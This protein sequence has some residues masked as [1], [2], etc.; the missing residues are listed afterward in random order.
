MPNVFCCPSQCRRGSESTGLTNYVAV[1]GENTAWPGEVSISFADFTDG[2]SNTLLLLEVNHKTIFWTEPTEIDK[3]EAINT[4]TSIEL[5]PH[6]G[7]CLIA[8]TDGSVLFLPRPTDQVGSEF[9]VTRNDGER[10][11]VDVLLNKVVSA[12]SPRVRNWI[13]LGVFLSLALSPLA[14]VWIKPHA[15][16]DVTHTNEESSRDADLGE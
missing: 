16:H 10:F 15:K 12:P 7:G 5:P 9:L 6:P 14:W 3:A 2:T 1:L 4:L 11:S 13:P 8:I